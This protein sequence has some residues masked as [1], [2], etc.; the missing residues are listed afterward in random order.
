MKE[1]LELGTIVELPKVDHYVMI[2]GR[3]NLVTL[4]NQTHYYDYCGC[5]YPEGMIDNKVLCFNHDQIEGI[6][7]EGPY[8]NKEPELVE[9]ILKSR[10]EFKDLYTE[11][12]IHEHRI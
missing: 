3:G 5:I 1:V 11:G 9:A 10:E 6:F 8:T 7:I 4:D 12:G 2:I